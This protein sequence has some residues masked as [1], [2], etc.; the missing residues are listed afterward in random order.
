MET[1]DLFKVNHD[2]IK[3]LHVT[4]YEFIAS[5]FIWFNMTPFPVAYPDLDELE[6]KINRLKKELIQTAKETGINS[7]DTLRCSQKLDE[8]ITLH[9]KQSI[10]N[11][12][13]FDQKSCIEM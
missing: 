4:W 9:Q 13:K 6:D 1:A 5:F 7:Y 10:K 3:N 2:S 12:Q 11:L 8:L